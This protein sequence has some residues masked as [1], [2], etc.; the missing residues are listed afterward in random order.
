MVKAQSH[1]WEGGHTRAIAAEQTIGV[2]EETKWPTKVTV[3][4][5]SEDTPTLS[6]T[7]SSEASANKSLADTH[8]TGDSRLI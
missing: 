5:Y 4:E 3:R 7:M 2:K 1:S 6:L 8:K